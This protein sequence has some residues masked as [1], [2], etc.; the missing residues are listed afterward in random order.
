MSDLDVLPEAMAKVTTWWI[1]LH[2]GLACFPQSSLLEHVFES[3]LCQEYKCAP[4]F[5][6][7]H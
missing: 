1:V 7:K 6:G 3:Y 2:R 4:H 5:E